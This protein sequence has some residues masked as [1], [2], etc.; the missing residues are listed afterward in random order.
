MLLVVG[1]SGRSLCRW[2]LSNSYA[3]IP[4]LPRFY[5]RGTHVP[6]FPSLQ[7]RFYAKTNQTN[8]R[9]GE[10]AQGI[11]VIASKPNKLSLILGG[12]T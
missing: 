11:Q 2:V 4:S 8:Y 12:L 1:P 5:G 9:A 10:M 3:V 7:L 6:I